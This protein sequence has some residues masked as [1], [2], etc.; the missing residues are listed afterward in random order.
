M[1]ALALCS[2][3]GAAAEESCVVWVEGRAA[4]DRTDQDG[5][6]RNNP[7]HTLYPNDMFGF[8]F[9][10]GFSA[11]CISPHVGT[12][13]EAGAVHKSRVVGPEN[14]AVEVGGGFTY[15]DGVILVGPA[16]EC[17]GAEPAGGGGLDGYLTG[18]GEVRECGELSLTVWAYKLVCGKTCRLVRVS[19]TDT[20]TPAV[21][22]PVVH[23]TLE[24]HMLHDMQGYPAVNLDATYYVWDPAGIIHRAVFE[25]KDE[26]S[27]TISFRYDREHPLLHEEGGFGCDERCDHA[28][29]PDGTPAGTGF[30]P[31]LGTYGNGDG[32]YAYVAPSA[33]S[34]GERAITYGV[35]VLN[36]GVPINLHRNS[37]RIT[38]VEYD[39]VFAY[40]PYTVLSDGAARSYSDRQGVLLRYEGS[41]ADDT[42]HADRRSKITNFYPQTVARS[43][44]DLVEP[45]A[46]ERTM[47]WNSTWAPPHPGGY[48]GAV[49]HFMDV[50]DGSPVLPPHPVHSTSEGGCSGAEAARH[51]P[52]E[53]H[54][55]FLHAS[56]GAVRF[57]QDVGVI[58]AEQPHKWYHNV[59]TTN[60]LASDDWAGSVRH[61]LFNYTYAYPHAPLAHNFTMQSSPALPLEAGITPHGV[62]HRYHAGLPEYGL[63]NMHADALEPI[64]VD[65]SR[66]VIRTDDYIRAKTLYDT[67]DYAMAAMAG[68]EVY[69]VAQ[70]GTGH[71]LLQMSLNKTGLQFWS[72]ALAA[73]GYDSILDM[74]V[75]EALGHGAHYEFALSAGDGDRRFVAPF[76]FDASRVERVYAGEA[77]AEVRREGPHTVRFAVPYEFGAVGGLTVQ[78][79]YRR[80]DGECHAVHCTVHAGAAGGTLVAYNLWGGTA[81]GAIPAYDGTPVAG[82]AEEQ[83]R[84][85]AALA[86]PM[87]V[88]LAVLA[89][90]RVARRMMGG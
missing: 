33:G 64:R 70:N 17:H 12:I 83:G 30:L 8:T 3:C 14:Q 15:G 63:V 62:T 11:G 61:I 65:A 26:R 27:G 46:V 24:R 28:L 34:L 90:W 35:T 76:E 75:Y 25:F 49:E 54:V 86:P 66:V 58:L 85:L 40:H 44:S 81:V 48:A 22:A 41:R 67:G 57:W 88:V 36:E 2:A 56:H 16:N 13:R 51:H 10:Y 80:F 21:V 50:M 47:Q 43:A 69:D 23:T 55:M 74:S 82:D 52:F 5:N 32:A 72:G 38:I 59:T 20:I 87:A 77:A 73:R 29:K 60:G 42:I 84:M 31:Y 78:E 79:E 4:Y 53:C 45:Y 7:D 68:S 39:P 18:F 89:C 37:T 19:A 71:G 6:P 9:S 1:A